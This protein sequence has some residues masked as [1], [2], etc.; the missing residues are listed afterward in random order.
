MISM[1]KQYRTRD[2]HEV[3]LLMTDG[4]GYY[5]IVG[6]YFGEGIW[7][8]ASW[9]SD[10]CYNTNGIHKRLD[11]IEVKP[12]ITRTY[13][14][15]HSQHLAPALFWKGDQYDSNPKERALAYAKAT[16]YVL[17]ITGPH[18]ITFEEGEGL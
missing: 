6:A 9:T 14:M 5:P 7:R 12:K 17:A 10:G 1:D 16:A 4:G 11:L 3:R 18:E 8:E 2:G 15:V 13:W